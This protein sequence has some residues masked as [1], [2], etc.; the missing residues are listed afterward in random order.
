[1]DTHPDQSTPEE[2]YDQALALFRNARWDEAISV[3]RQ[4]QAQSNAYPEAEAMLDDIQ[5]K[6]GLER[7]QA[8][9]AAAPPREQTKR[10]QGVIVAAVTLVAVSLISG[11]LIFISGSSALPLGLTSISQQ[12]AVGALPTAA[13]S[14]PTATT[15]VILPGIGVLTVAQTESVTTTD[16]IYFILDASG[17]MLAKINNQRKIDMAHEAMGALVRDLSS[18]TNIALRTYGR[19]RTNDCSDIELIS[20]MGPLNRD[21]LLAQINSIVPVNRS[22]TPLGSSLAA[23]SADLAG[24]TGQ[25]LVVLLSDGEENCNGDP[26]AEAT[27]LHTSNPNVRV[28]VVGFDIAPELQAR[29][30]AIA[31]AGGGS[32]FGAADVNQ[33]GAA[34]KQAII[35]NYR[36][37]DARDQEVGHANVGDSLKLPTGSY[38]V[39][40]GGVPPL[41]EQT[42]GIR[43]DMVTVMTI[44]TDKGRLSAKLSRNWVK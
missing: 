36:V 2:L 7:I 28:S 33:L 14:V 25:T 22:N 6:Q 17:S 11:L 1:M 26:V 23:L 20:P 44:S 18:S 12:A 41:L 8:P 4:L 13:P 38:R 39:V 21:T 29:L 27:R 30:A 5:L 9:I 15:E 35:L 42:V 32:Y 43:K 37:Y 34:L 40:I 31:E 19:N 16:N 24:V 10:G 3:L